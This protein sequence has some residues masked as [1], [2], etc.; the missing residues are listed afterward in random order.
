[1]ENDNKR[2]DRGGTH[3][4][5]LGTMSSTGLELHRKPTT[6]GTRFYL[7]PFPPSLYSAVCRQ[8]QNVYSVLHGLSNPGKRSSKRCLNAVQWSRNSRGE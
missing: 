1:M 6:P 2:R 3:V 4:Q 5:T 8:R 7:C